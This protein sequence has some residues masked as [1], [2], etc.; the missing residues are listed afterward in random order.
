MLIELV[1]SEG[2]HA[3]LLRRRASAKEEEGT[4][5][6]PSQQQRRE[7]A[8][9]S[10]EDETVAARPQ[11]AAPHTSRSLRF[12][13][14]AS[15]QGQQQASDP[16]YALGPFEMP[17]PRIGAASL[18]TQ[19][20][21]LGPL[22][23]PMG[24]PVAHP[25]PAA[26]LGLPLGPAAPQQQQPPVQY[27]QPRQLQQPVQP[28][29][30]S[31][32]YFAAPGFAA[33]PQPQ[34]L[35]GE[36]AYAASLILQQQ[37][38]IAA[39]RQQ[40]TELQ[41]Y[42]APAQLPL[43]FDSQQVVAQQLRLHQLQQQQLLEQQQQAEV[44]RQLVQQNQLRAFQQQQALQQPQ[45]TTPGADWYTASGGSLGALLPRF[46]SANEA[47]M[48]AEA[49]IAAAGGSE[50][51][52]A[53]VTFLERRSSHG[54][55][56]EEGADEEDGEE[57][58]EEGARARQQPAR[59]RRLLSLDASFQPPAPQVAAATPLLPAKA[60]PAGAGPYVG[61]LQAASNAGALP[62]AAAPAAT[63]GGKGP[64]PKTVPQVRVSSLPSGVLGATM[65]AARA[66]AKTGVVFGPTT[67]FLASQAPPSAPSLFL[68]KRRYFELVIGAPPKPPKKKKKRAPPAKKA[69]AAS[70]A[71][72]AAARTAAVYAPLPSAPPPPASKTS[73]VSL[74]PSRTPSRSPKPTASRVPRPSRS[75]PPA[76]KLPS[77]DETVVRVKT[78]DGRVLEVRS[79]TPIENAKGT[80]DDWGNGAVRKDGYVLPAIVDDIAQA[81]RRPGVMGGLLAAAQ[82]DRIDVA[83]GSRPVGPPVL[84]PAGNIL[85][86]SR[87]V[88]LLRRRPARPAPLVVAV[89]PPIIASS[90]AQLFTPRSAEPIAVP[91]GRRVTITI[92]PADSGAAG[93]KGG[94]KGA[95]GGKK[96]GKAAAGGKKAGAKASAGKKTAS[97][98]K[99]GK[100][101]KSAKAAPALLLELSAAAGHEAQTPEADTA[102]KEVVGTLEQSI[103]RALE[104]LQARQRAAIAVEAAPPAVPTLAGR[105]ATAAKR[106]AAKASPLGPLY[107][108][109]ATP[110]VLTPAV[111]RHARG[112]AASNPLYR[113]PS[114]PAARLSAAAGGKSGVAKKTGTVQQ[115]Q[116]VQ[117]QGA[118]GG[119]RLPLGARAAPHSRGSPAPTAE[120][121][122]FALPPSLTAEDRRSL[123]AVR[124]VVKQLRSSDA[125]AAGAEQQQRFRGVDEGL[126]G[127]GGDRGVGASSSVA[128]AAAELAGSGALP[129]HAPEANSLRSESLQALAETEGL[130]GGEEEAGAPRG[131][132]LAARLLAR[133]RDA[134]IAARAGQS[135][136]L[137][138]A[139]LASAAEVEGEGQ[140]EGHSSL[141]GGHDSEEE[142]GAAAGTLPAQ[143]IVSRVVELA[144]A[145]AAVEHRTPLS[146]E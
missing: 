60:A 17:P 70:P 92:A 75:A 116:Q 8:A 128:S 12:S 21:S 107:S 119:A 114:L 115:R 44:Y 74:S 76:R 131:V 83:V 65:V 111:H 33:A 104:E 130:A 94:K 23:M 30:G 121:S 19:G 3:G 86:P 47:A 39:L 11:R 71:D 96:G 87:P 64:S 90:E 98:G 58:E 62:P 79:E 101:S 53:G 26:W 135:Q 85:Q 138:D 56:A 89:E 2:G 77:F 35:Q 105:K 43:A 81:R 29:L 103:N 84:G 145:A 36:L 112:P 146:T 16:Q 68:P 72:A 80:E 51:A 15:A 120:D 122:F 38:Q 127:G 25:Q 100:K 67:G 32:G 57:D 7:K 66:L 6:R 108:M 31:G 59:G 102:A 140:L 95:K 4:A 54:S 41:Q 9:D 133:A 88:L 99:G 124:G 106:P 142:D 73:S 134:A 113:M 20:P 123:A 34:P 118:A 46:A 52:Q 42:P 137:A 48:G 91:K 78:K 61:P 143:A 27:L 97:T 139:D 1:S 10:D 18:P 129:L 144:R 82:P 14:S 40:V 37:A 109:P 63:A 136:R 13:T 55:D 93:K 126:A 117:R 50:S 110:D 22:Q 45:L 132:E 24:L 125:G 49:D 69:P 5:R 141:R 28:V